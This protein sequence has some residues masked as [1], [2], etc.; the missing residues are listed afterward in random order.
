[1]LVPTSAQ[2][3]AHVDNKDRGVLER[4]MDI[5]TFNGKL[6]SLPSTRN[7]LGKTSDY[8]IDDKCIQLVSY[9]TDSR[10]Y[11][12]PYTQYDRIVGAY[13]IYTFK[14]TIYDDGAFRFGDGKIRRFGEVSDN[15]L[16]NDCYKAKLL[17]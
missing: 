14:L 1:M 12:I 7:E 16:S 2:Y 4:L 3:F 8:D 11:Y 13:R 10:T 6:F 17:Y 9:D 5:R 15:T